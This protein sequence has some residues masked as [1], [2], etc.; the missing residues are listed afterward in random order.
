MIHQWNDTTS[1]VWKNTSGVRWEGITAGVASGAYEF[2]ATATALNLALA[3]ASG[4]YEFVAAAIAKNY[5]LASA[6]GAYEFTATATA[7]NLALASASGA[8]EFVAT[9]VAGIGI[10]LMPPQMHQ[11]I[12]DPYS[13]G[14]WLW[15]VRIK[16]PGY[17]PLYYASNTENITY[18]GKVYVKN[19]FKVGLA[20]LV[21]DGSVPRS[22]LVIAQ[23][24]GY[25][26]EDIINATQGAGNG[27]VKI[28]RAHEDHLD[29][30]I[31]ELE[32]EVKILVANSDSKDVTFLLGIPDPL[33]KKVPLRRYSSKTCPYAA[34]SLF[35]GVECQYAGVDATCTGKY[36]DC[37][38]KGN[39]ALWGGE[40]GLD[41]AVGRA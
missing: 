11:G 25:V 15:L 41:P 1:V 17:T 40:I 30:F 8:Y 38:T 39:S 32:Q 37:F 10:Q 3:S 21:G 6:T 35:K 20:S 34:P 19:N 5:Q 27:V 29:K 14:A 24:G 31:V 4:A 22:G 26:L 2:T 36:E 33:L 28:I 12:I 13:G 7:L 18:A 23:E 9:A 16:I